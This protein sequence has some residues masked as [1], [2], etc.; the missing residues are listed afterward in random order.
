M[1]PPITPS[2]G[3]DRGHS[4]K[5]NKSETSSQHAHGVSFGAALTNECCLTCYGPRLEPVFAPGRCGTVRLVSSLADCSLRMVSLWHVTMRGGNAMEC[6][7]RII[8]NTRRIPEAMPQSAWL[9]PGAQ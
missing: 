1:Q 3:R 6:G 8:D 9:H 4:H 2:N 7:N 5:G